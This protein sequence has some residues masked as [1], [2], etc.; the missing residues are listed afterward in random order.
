[1]EKK[2]AIIPARGGSKRIPRKNIKDFFGKPIIAYSIEVALQ[3][4]L[5]DEVMVSTDDEEIADIAVNYGA[6]VPFLRSSENSDD[7]AATAD[8]LLEVIDK[9]KKEFNIDIKTACCIYP[10][11]PLTQISQLIEGNRLLE[12]NNYDSVFPVVAFSFPV[13][14]GIDL[15][16]QNLVTMQWPEFYNSRS[17]DLKTLYHDAGQWYWFNSDSLKESKK[18]YMNKSYG[19]VLDDTEVQDIDNMV[20]FKLAELKYQLLKDILS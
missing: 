13:W 18:L 20:D 12:V 3:S 17:Q 1:M 8:V 7:L 6:K 19:Y 11:S 10:T 9:Y 2:I 15:D 5:F 4:G 16:S 14:R